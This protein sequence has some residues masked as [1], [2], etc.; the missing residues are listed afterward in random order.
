MELIPN[1]FSYYAIFC[2]TTAICIVYL[3]MRA[4]REVG[5]K[6][7]FM[8][9]FIYYGVST[10]IFLIGAPMFFLIFIFRSDK[11]LASL[12]GYITEIYLDSDDES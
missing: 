10:P 9:G 2:V 12:K 1:V 11:Y 8:G 6:W 3:N 7:N 4:F 5:F